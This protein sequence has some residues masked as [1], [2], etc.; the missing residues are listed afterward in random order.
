M[1]WF[2]PIEQRIVNWRRWRQTL[3]SVNSADS[4][5]DVQNF[6]YSAPLR[7]VSKLN[8]QIETWPDPWRLLDNMSYCE[9]MKALGMFYTTALVPHLLL[10]K[11]ELHLMYDSVGDRF[12]VVS[13]DSGRY[14]L[15][16]NPNSVVNTQ[17]INTEYQILA[18]YYPTDFK[19]L[20]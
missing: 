14:V 20:L 18:R 2:D 15:N 7:K 19:S 1:N 16:F 10:L 6:W 17:S 11:P 8:D 9:R 3:S 12:T 5:L 13:L 4:L